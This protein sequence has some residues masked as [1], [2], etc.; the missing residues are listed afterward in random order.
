MVGRSRRAGFHV[1]Q[2]Q[3]VAAAD[4]VVGIHAV[5]PQRVDARLAD[6]VGGNLRHRKRLEAELRQRNRDVR[7][8]AGVAGDELLGL[9]QTLVV[10]RA[11]TQQQLSE[12]HD[13]LHQGSSPALHFRVRAC[14]HSSP[15]FS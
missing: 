14:A 3:P 11:E 8:G 1:E 13:P 9:Q 7:L 6:L 12:G 10:L 15:N 2:P 4:D 5:P